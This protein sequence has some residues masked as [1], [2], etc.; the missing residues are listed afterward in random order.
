[1]GGKPTPLL[2]SH[3]TVCFVSATSW[4]ADYRFPTKMSILCDV[5]VLNLL[6]SMLVLYEEGKQILEIGIEE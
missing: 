4:P 2:I 3:S 5:N 1:M 6:C